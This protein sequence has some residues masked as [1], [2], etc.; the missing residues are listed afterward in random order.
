MTSRAATIG[1]IGANG[2]LGRAFAQAV[3][4]GGLV[5]PNALWLSSRSPAEASRALLPEARWTADNQALVD[6]SDVV[7]LSVHPEQFDAVRVD[8]RGKVV[9]SFMAGVPMKVLADRLNTARVVRAMPN[10]AAEIRRSYTPWFA[11]P[12]LT[13]AERPGSTNC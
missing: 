3:V 9:V 8:A 10:A 5:G 13:G 12:D 1:I 11:A 7:L 6:S 4:D 2:W